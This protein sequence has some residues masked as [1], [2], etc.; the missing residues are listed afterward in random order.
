MKSITEKTIADFQSKIFLWWEENKRELPWRETTNPYYI[1]ISEVMLQQTQVNRTI[2]KY[3]EFIERFPTIE[4]LAEAER[5]EVLRYWS[6]LGYNRRALWLQEAVQQ[7]LEQG[8]FPEAQEDLIKLKGI[9]PYSS[10]SI[11]IFAF[12]QDLATIDTNIRRILIAEE[13]A[14]ET[15]T[16][17]ELY[18]IASKLVPKGK[19]RDWHNALM[20]YGSL[21]LTTAKTGIKPTSSQPKYK[22]SKR[23]YRGQIVKF[24]TTKESVTKSE[25]ISNCSIPKEISDEILES[26]TK[27]GLIVQKK[28]RYSLP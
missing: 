5:A 23:F 3:L 28:K 24:L 25:L 17:K 1:L 16:E 4:S 6:G 15:T 14:E 22:S 8:V 13:F 19:S 18:E 11:L 21:V 9:G 2:E 26:L 20:D 7:I 27:D 12:N 10:R